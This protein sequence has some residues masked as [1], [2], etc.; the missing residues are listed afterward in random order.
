MKT[1]M[2]YKGYTGEVAYDPEAKILYGHV[3]DFDDVIA[4]ESERAD[5]IE[6]EFHRSVDVYLDWCAERGKEPKKPFSGKLVLRIPPDV[7]HDAMIAAARKQKSL[8]AWLADVVERAAREEVMT[9]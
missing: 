4:F 9:A 7:H 5:E 8:N 2:R 1:T 3:I 6:D